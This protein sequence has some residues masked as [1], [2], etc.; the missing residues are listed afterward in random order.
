MTFRLQAHTSG[1]GGFNLE[2]LNLTF[3]G[4]LE[5]GVARAHTLCGENTEA[6]NNTCDLNAYVNEVRNI[7]D[8]P[9]ESDLSLMEF[10]RFKQGAKMPI[11][12]YHARKVAAFHQALPDGGNSQFEYLK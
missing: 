2:T 3:L 5:D 6:F 12:T 8:P 11:T 1:L 4:C 9:Q 7:F 10:E